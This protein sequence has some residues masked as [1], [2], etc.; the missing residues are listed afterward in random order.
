M[1]V[2]PKSQLIE[3]LKP[4][5]PQVDA[6]RTMVDGAYALAEEA[7][8]Q[9]RELYNLRAANAKQTLKEAVESDLGPRLAMLAR[10]ASEMR[11]R[12]KADRK[13]FAG[14][15]YRPTPEMKA[16]SDNVAL[17]DAAL[18]AA[19]KSLSTMSGVSEVTLEFM[20]LA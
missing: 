16:L 11:E 15:D 19:R 2:I 3:R 12:V 14:V 10:S 4:G 18:W 1:M 5:T 8:M 6:C 9:R 17:A 13:A 7:E 20:A